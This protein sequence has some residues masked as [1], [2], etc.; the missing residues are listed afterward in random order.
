MKTYLIST[1]ASLGTI[2]AMVSGPVETPPLQVQSQATAQGDQP[3]LAPVL[4][5]EPSEAP[6]V[7]V[8]SVLE[9]Q[10]EPQEPTEAPTPPLIDPAALRS[11]ETKLDALAAKVDEL[12]SRPAPIQAFPT[13]D[14]IAMRV[15]ERVAEKVVDKVADKVVEKIKNLLIQFR[16]ADGTVQAKQVPI[17]PTTGS[18]EFKL[19]PG[20]VLTHIDGVPV[21]QTASS[22]LSQAGWSAPASAAVYENNQYRILQAAPNQMRILPRVFQPF[23]SQG[24]CRIIN[25]VKVCN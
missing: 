8:V 11:M 20:E 15:A 25:G 24:Q 3:T 7:R 23:Q 12:S 2:F 16:A 22:V 19:G 4:K 10:A 13:A 14:E 6:S 9:P 1:L 5:E 18:G 17:S 21:Q